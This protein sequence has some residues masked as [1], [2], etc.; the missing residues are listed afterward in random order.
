MTQQRVIPVSEDS[1]AN[2][3]P[4]PGYV[5]LPAKLDEK[6]TALFDVLPKSD[7]KCGGTGRNTYVSRQ[8][9]D[10]GPV[11][12]VREV[13]PCECV[14]R[15]LENFLKS[16]DAEPTKAVVRTDLERRIHNAREEI[17]QIDKET[18]AKIQ[19]VEASIQNDL[20]ARTD[21]E[22]S[23]EG[24][25]AEKAL[26]CDEVVRQLERTQAADEADV[27]KRIEELKLQIIESTEGLAERTNTRSAMRDKH[28]QM[29]EEARQ[30]ASGVVLKIQE[31]QKRIQDSNTRVIPA[32][33]ARGESR[34]KGPSKRLERLMSEQRRKAE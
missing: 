26:E 9:K 22:I 18:A 13:L 17:A 34:K 20:K 12:P 23:D 1:Q 11:K 27:Q 29:A 10:G 16:V 3:E 4:A 15:R 8:S 6:Q 2:S 7:C 24:M 19:E 33:R 31:M 14:E 28:R 30:A 21:L 5:R 25:S 32:I